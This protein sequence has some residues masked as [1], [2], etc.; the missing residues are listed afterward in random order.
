M[1]DV[2]KRHSD[3]AATAFGVA[4]AAGPSMASIMALLASVLHSVEYPGF[5]KG[6]GMHIRLVRS[7][8]K[9]K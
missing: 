8:E 5:F 3:T 2:G 7:R 1:H 4:A 6:G 9:A